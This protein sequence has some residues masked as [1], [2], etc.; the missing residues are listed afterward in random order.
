MCVWAKTT[1]FFLIDFV[2]RFCHVRIV[3]KTAN[4]N[5]KFLVI[6]FFNVKYLVIFSFNGKL[7]KEIFIMLYVDVAYY[8]FR[9]EKKSKFYVFHSYEFKSFVKN[10]FLSILCI[11]YR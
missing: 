10:I 11:M 2:H 6:L 4:Y 7:L 1:P 3:F 9:F 8:F 5:L